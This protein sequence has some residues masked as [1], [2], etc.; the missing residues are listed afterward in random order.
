MTSNGSMTEAVA[1]RIRRGLR[2]FASTGDQPR[3]RRATDLV[4]LTLST[5]GIVLVGLIAV[6]EPGFSRAVSGFLL[7]LPTALTGMW[8]VFGD[9]PAL[10]A[11]V[12]LVAAFSRGRAKVGRDMVLAI[13]VGVVLWLV[14]GRMVT[15]AWPELQRLFGDVA[16]PPVFPPARLGVPAALA[17]HRI[18]TPRATG[19]T[20]RLPRHRVRLDR[21]GRARGQLVG[22]SRRIAAVRWWRCRN[23]ALVGGSSAGRPSLDDVRFALADMKIEIAELGVADRQ[24][25]GNFAVAARATDGAELIV[26]LYG[27]DA[28]DAALVSTVWRTI[29]LRQPGT[30]VGLGR[31]RQVE[32]EA[33]MTLLAAQA[34]IVTDA[35]VTAGATATDDALLVLRRTG[36]PLVPPDR[37]RDVD[38]APDPTFDDV[39]A[40]PRLHEL[41]QLL[42]HPARQRPRAR[43]ARRGAPDR[44]RRTPG[45]RPVPRR[46]RWR[47]LPPRCEATTCSSS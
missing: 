20:L 46:Q 15:G 27:R 10:W 31:L 44:R 22:G 23:R 24:D 26:K 5:I 14:L 17:D 8:Q 29:W 32:H 33:L 38:E 16:P 13:V 19:A 28:Y 7:S 41:W 12:V 1:G 34:G 30:P 42:G 36:T 11:L 18:A 35:V 47:R 21:H 3:A 40:R 9:L 6:P 45:S 4:L 2:L 43:P 25:A 37:F 39:E